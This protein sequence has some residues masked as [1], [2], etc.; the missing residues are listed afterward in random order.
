M[1]ITNEPPLRLTISGNNV[2]HPN[3]LELR[4][5]V[6]MA[7]IFLSSLSRERLFI[8]LVTVDYQLIRTVISCDKNHKSQRFHRIIEVLPNLQQGFYPKDQFTMKIL[9]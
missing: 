1:K 2:L 9:P 6:G 8:S 3:N 5:I 7:N 4:A